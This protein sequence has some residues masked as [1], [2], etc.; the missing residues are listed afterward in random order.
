MNY[1]RELLSILCVQKYSE[2]DT[3][4][5]KLRVEIYDKLSD[6][7]ERKIFL[8]TYDS[9]NQKL[10]QAIYLKNIE[11]KLDRPQWLSND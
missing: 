6:E 4:L 10:E 11:Y 9:M 3:Q 8:D 2:V 5:E 7:A 1:S